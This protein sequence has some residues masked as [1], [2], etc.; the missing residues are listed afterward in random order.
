MSALAQALLDLG[1]QV[2]GSD[3]V[4][5][6]A[7]RDLRAHGARVE[8]GPHVASN[9]GEPLPERVVVTAALQA[10]NP[11]WLEAQRLGLPV[12]KRA[13]CSGN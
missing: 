9:L 1:D 7:T 2:S 5:T 13:I 12:V 6:D 8:M 3:A 10:D 11:E 4:E